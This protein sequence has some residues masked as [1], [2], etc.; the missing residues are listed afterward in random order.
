MEGDALNAAG[1][2]RGRHEL[3]NGEIILK[4]WENLPHRTALA[5]LLMWLISVFGGVPG[6]SDPPARRRS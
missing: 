2:L 4:M 5:L 6:M 3:M 1:F